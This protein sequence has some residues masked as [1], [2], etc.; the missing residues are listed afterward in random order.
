MIKIA[1]FV[2]EDEEHEG[3]RRH[4]QQVILAKIRNSVKRMG[5]R[6]QIVGNLWCVILN[7]RTIN[8]TK[9]TNERS[10]QDPADAEIPQ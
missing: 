1:N 4:I 3:R 6:T 5:D 9:T 10:W 2:K 8:L 7:A